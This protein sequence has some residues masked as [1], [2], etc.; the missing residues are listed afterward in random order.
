MTS[1]LRFLLRVLAAMAVCA[2]FLQGSAHAQ[3]DLASITGIVTDTTGAV[4]P[5]VQVTVTNTQ[6]GVS[7]LASTNHSG[8][9][10][11]FNL[12]IGEY[13]VTF[14]GKGFQPYVRKGLTLAVSQVANINATLAVG[15]EATTVQ[16]DSSAPL[17]QTQDA[18]VQVTL[19]N[20]TVTNMPLSIQ[21]GRSLST[22]MFAYMPGVEGSDYS[23]HINGSPAMTKEV[24]IDGTSAVSQLGGYLSESQPPMEAVNQF[25]V[26][27]AG[28][29]ANEGSTGGGVF[30]YEMKSGTNA[31]HG[32]VFGFLRNKEFDANDWFNKLTY[33][34]SYPRPADSMSQWGFGVG[35]PLIKDKLFWYGAYERYMYANFGPGGLGS[36]VPNSDFLTGDLSALLDKSVVLG[37][38]SAGNTIYQGAIFDPTTGDV[39][40]N[41]KIP[42]TR[43]SAVSQKIVDLYKKYYQPV[44]NPTG[45]AANNAMPAQTL[46]WQHI[47]EVS[48][49]IDYAMS[50]RNRFSG[51]YIY[52]SSPRILADQGGI[53]SRNATDG[54]PMANAYDH[55]VHAPSARIAWF[56]TANDHLLNTAHFTFNRFYNPSRAIS[57]KDGWDK[58]VGL[59]DFG[60]GNFPKISFGGAS[61]N[62]NFNMSPLG[63]QFNDFYAANTF[64]WNDDMI[65]VKGKHTFDFGVELRAQQFNS[66]ADQD[67]LNVSFDGAQTGDPTAPYAS[68]V[69]HSFA[70]FLLGAA[71]SA[72]VS[73]QNWLFGRRKSFAAYVTDDVRVTPTLTFNLDLRWDWNSPYKEKN[74]HWSS[75]NPTAPNPV[76]GTPGALTFLSNGSQSFTTRQ[77]W[78]NFA[79]HI[80]ASWQ[81]TPKTVV[82]GAFSVFYT[83]LNLNSWGAVPYSFDPG[84]VTSSQIQPSGQRIS[85]WEN[86]D[87][88]YGNYA[89]V[90]HGVKDPA[91]TQW[92]MVQIDPRMLTPGNTQQYMFGVERSLGR[93]W[94]ATINMIGN[95]SYHLQ[96]S[97]L[98][99]NQEPVAAYQALAA[100]G[101]QWNWVSDPSSAAAAGVPYPYPGF[102]G[103]AYMAITPNPL[104]ATSYGPLFVVGSPVGNAD[105]KS[106][107]VLVKR[108]VSNGLSMMASYVLSSAHGDTDNNFQELW[109]TGSIQNIYDRASARKDV[110]SFD[111]TH[112]VKGYVS[113]ILPFGRGRRFLGGANRL[114]D[115]I[116]NNWMLNGDFHYA[117][118]TPMQVFS[119]NYYPGF[120]SVYINLVPGC[121]A[122]TGHKG[123][124]SQYLNP[125]CF[126][127]PDASV[128]ALGT[129]GNYLASVRNIGLATEDLGIIKAVNLSADG[130]V[131]LQLRGD[132]FN[133]FN[134]RGLGA[135]DTSI[136][137]NTFGQVI[138]AGA[139]GNRNGQ[140]GA[141]IS[142]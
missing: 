124:G 115:G 31:I 2:L 126:Q 17:L 16:V 83:P 136:T 80:G 69:G 138:G 79:P 75:F 8:Y 40:V 131:K 1:H 19:D 24:M 25:Q 95:H 74:G 22:F 49:K 35:G 71:N 14:T 29:R 129:G 59:G 62:S 98:S 37:T 47:N 92:G 132:F 21:G 15:S 13:T 65:L 134:R 85:K 60:S 109:W 48:G 125:A 36:I 64:I 76:T 133:I 4:I 3:R 26:D 51:S 54:G 28:I 141:R 121:K 58:Q 70:S 46:P 72:G 30:K 111:Q 57:G 107:Q 90:T 102:A 87:T 117:S 6:T 61:Y 50:N 103:S 96:T 116:V 120:N 68:Q 56:F 113:Y 137:S 128:G 89:T 66:H 33:G 139:P 39:F 140:V 32:G 91:Y 27:T 100:K 135:V 42:T 7:T 53:W 78:T 20:Q 106:M 10:R 104:V 101:T 119:S 45:A 63:S 73:Q 18:K 108:N 105:Y 94:V 86:W 81:V 52:N 97:V 43:F 67:V 11:A 44:V 38:D 93:N 12:P 55:F 23:S 84:Y 123:I 127:N 34:P 41:N 118:G 142:F 9:Y 110:A 88:P 122:T 99:G 77:V 114:V 130:R 82:H 112:I 5:G